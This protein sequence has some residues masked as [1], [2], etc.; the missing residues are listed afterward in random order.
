MNRFTLVRL[1]TLAEARARVAAAPQDREFRAGGID[2]I[3]RM[4]EGL[5]EPDELVELHAVAGDEGRAMRGI[6]KAEGGAFTIG[7]L[8][9][10]AQIAGFED[11]P[12]GF[13]ALREA[14][15]AAATPG[16]RNAATLGGNLL[17]RP[18]CWYYRHSDMPCLKKGGFEC[19][20]VTGDNRFNAILGGGPS[21]I[22]HPSSLASPL[23]AL[24]AKVNV[25]GEGGVRQI[26]IEELFA[27]PTVDPKREH[28]LKAGE[29]LLSVELPAPLPGQRSAYRY[30][31][32]K[33]SHDW[34]LGEAA[35]RCTIA[36]G[37]ITHVRVA[38]GHVAPIPWRSP[39]AEKVL[40]GKT[41]SPELFEKAAA[42]AMTRAKPLPRNAYKIPLSQGLLRQALHAAASI[43]LPE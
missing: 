8:V 25:A 42:A 36:D 10:L 35:V 38:L 33:Q 19:L 30:A 16:I 13:A 43:P 34:P 20:A 37:K 3:D 41:A 39:E 7:A 9:T 22:V 23:V 32:E 27:P 17:Q 1:A 6:A 2:L 26:D 18:R 14:A 5:D 24:G 11:L 29:V 21:F 40:E 15:D 28:T 4:K 12:T 31:K